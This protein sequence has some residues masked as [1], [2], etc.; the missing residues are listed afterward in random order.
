[1]PAPRIKSSHR[2]TLV[3]ST[4]AHEQHRG[5]Q[6]LGLGPLG[7]RTPQSREGGP[8][9]ETADGSE[10][11]AR[12]SIGYALESP[13]GAVQSRAPTRPLTWTSG[14]VLARAAL[15]LGVWLGWGGTTLIVYALWDLLFILAE[16]VQLGRASLRRWPSRGVDLRTTSSLLGRNE[17]LSQDRN[18]Y[19]PYDD[20]RLGSA[21]S[22]RSTNS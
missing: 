15:V 11:R 20:P 17:I 7:L 4:E 21:A 6:R 22:A 1:V 2:P 3:D 12:R 16:L 10:A 8:W 13:V 9:Q 5:P 18:G 14:R 19:R